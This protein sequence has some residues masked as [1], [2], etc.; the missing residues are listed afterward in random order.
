MHTYM[1]PEFTDT[2][3]IFTNIII[4]IKFA[5]IELNK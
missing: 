5:K 4:I 3:K 2:D 1:I